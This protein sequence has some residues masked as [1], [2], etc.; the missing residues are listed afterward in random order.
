MTT[1]LGRVLPHS[2]GQESEADYMGLLF[3][4]RAGMTRKL[5]SVS[6]SVLR[7]KTNPQEVLRQP[8][9]SGHIPWTKA[10]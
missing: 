1:Q 4:A 7:L 6:G 8:G 3:M 5:P 2:R 9:F 10:H